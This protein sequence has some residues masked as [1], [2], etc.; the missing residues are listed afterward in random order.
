MVRSEPATKESAAPAQNPR[1]LQ[2]TG[3]DMRSRI[4]QS[5]A[6]SS[7]RCSKFARNSSPGWSM[8]C[9]KLLTSPPAMKCSPAPVME[10][11]R[12]SGSFSM[13]RQNVSI[14]WITAPV[15][16]LRASGR[17]I[18]MRA[19]PSA[20]SQISSWLI[21]RSP[22][23]PLLALKVGRAPLEERLQSVLHVRGVQCTAAVE[24]RFHLALF[25]Q[26]ILERRIHELL[27]QAISDRGTFA[28]PIDQLLCFFLKLRSE[29]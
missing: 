3:L 9:M 17:L 24:L 10:R 20:T 12:T 4:A 2:T 22:C 29:E 27:D 14:S 15:M 26:G 7:E 19:M 28:Q 21:A 13:R 18:F 8:T 6:A 25:R 1:T 5:G 16:A 23:W 11:Q